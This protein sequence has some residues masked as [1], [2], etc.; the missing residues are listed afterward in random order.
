MDKKKLLTLEDGYEAPKYLY[1]GTDEKTARKILKEGIL[2]RSMRKRSGRGNWEHTV[3]SN[4]DTVYLTDIYGPYFAMNA[5][6]KVSNRFAV[7][8]V[9][10]DKL[11]ESLFRPDED[12]LEQGTRSI[13]PEKRQPLGVTDM[14]TRTLWFRDNI[15]LYAD[16]W[17]VSLQTLGTVGYKGH[18]PVEAIDAV[19]F[20]DWKS[21]AAL[22]SNI[23]DAMVILGNHRWCFRR[24]NAI[25][26]FFFGKPLDIYA[27]FDVAPGF[28]F[29]EEQVRVVNEELSKAKF[30]IIKP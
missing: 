17:P 19:S 21:S 14:K 18:I 13:P 8:R 26:E 25:T 16:A 27:L 20:Y 4:A 28:P 30:E 7:V 9:D 5:G 6:K 15:D 1:H 11:D 23:M 2:P 3:T 29:P 12:C 10:T 24:Y 22:T